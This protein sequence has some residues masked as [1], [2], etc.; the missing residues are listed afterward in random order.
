MPACVRS[1][2]LHCHSKSVY[3]L[4]HHSH[5]QSYSLD[6]RVAAP[7]GAT[8]VEGCRKFQILKGRGS[9]D[10]GSSTCARRLESPSR[11]VLVEVVRQGLRGQDRS[12]LAWTER[13]SKPSYTANHPQASTVDSGFS[14]RRNPR[15]KRN[16][17]LV[18]RRRSREFSPE[19]PQAHRPP[20]QFACS[21]LTRLSV[22]P[23]VGPDECPTSGAFC[24]YPRTL[25][26]TS[27][28][29][30]LARCG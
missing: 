23:T 26:P 27:T 8:Q 18:R 2:R 10:S 20:P 19:Q 11:A 28:R 7:L 1:T 12:T 16:A 9:F 17:P 15:E 24:L 6:R 5:I 25:L 13:M 3:S 4:Q 22:A 21:G 30:S 29:E 14:Q